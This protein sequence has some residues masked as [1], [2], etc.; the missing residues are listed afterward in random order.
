MSG[1]C[2]S[3]LVV[4]GSAR[5]RTHQAQLRKNNTNQTSDTDVWRVD[6]LMLA[7]AGARVYVCAYVYVR[8]HVHIRA[9]AF[10]FNL[11]AYSFLANLCATFSVKRE[12][13]SA[14]AL[15]IRVT[16]LF[17]HL[18]R[19]VVVLL[20]FTLPTYHLGNRFPV[21]LFCFVGLACGVCVHAHPPSKTKKEDT[22]TD[23][24]YVVTDGGCSVFFICR[25]SE[26]ISR[27]FIRIFFSSKPMRDLFC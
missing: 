18:K 17:T 19:G 16:Y 12:K 11:S 2:C 1:L 26:F 13:L 14:L 21:L 10:T 4:L 22:T 20:T 15:T 25:A 27:Y 8:A 6:Y 7:C 9:H 24:S 3:F 23:I 5:A